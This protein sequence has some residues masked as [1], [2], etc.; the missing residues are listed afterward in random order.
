MVN[1]NY[2]IVLVENGYSRRYSRRKAY[3][4]G[5]SRD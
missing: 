1:L 2:I 4:T 3:V 5:S